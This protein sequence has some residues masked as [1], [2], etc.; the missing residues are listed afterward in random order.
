MYIEW[1]IFLCR[2][3][4][5]RRTFIMAVHF[6]RFISKNTKTNQKKNKTSQR[7]AL[8]FQCT[9]CCVLPGKVWAPAYSLLQ[10]E[11]SS[12]PTS[13]QYFIFLPCRASFTDLSAQVGVQEL[14]S[15]ILMHPF[16][17]GIF[18]D[19]MILSWTSSYLQDAE[20]CNTLPCPDLA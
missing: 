14:N 17:L 10:P 4:V 16:E 1:I 18:Y 6:S 19:P 13:Q 11:G 5:A 15:M 9:L 20:P 7:T 2:R 12:P 8:G 3:K